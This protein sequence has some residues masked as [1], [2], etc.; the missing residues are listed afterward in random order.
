MNMHMFVRTGVRMRPYAPVCVRNGGW[1]A[2]SHCSYWATFG[3]TSKLKTDG[4]TDERTYGR[5]DVRTERSSYRDVKTHLKLYSNQCLTL[6]ICKRLDPCY[7]SSVPLVRLS[8]CLESI[9]STCPSV[10]PSIHPSI[11]ISYQG[12][13]V[14]QSCINERRTERSTDTYDKERLLDATT[15]LHYGSE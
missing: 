4:H 14:D 2:A 10:Y 9:W 1:F 7:P 5:T 8:V 3:S 11:I 13:Y 12:Y 15:D 6:N